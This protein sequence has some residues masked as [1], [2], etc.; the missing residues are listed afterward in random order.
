VQGDMRTLRLGRTFD[1]VFVHD[2]VMYV[3]TEDD[4]GAVIGTAAIHAAPGGVVILV[5]DTIRET[6]A[7]GVHEGGHDG[8]DDR[9]LRYLEWT[10]APD[11]GGTTFEVDYAIM[12]REPGEQVRVVHDHHLLGLFGR[13]TWRRLIDD[14]GLDLLDVAA[15]E[16]PH[17][18][19]FETFAAQRPA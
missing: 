2:A 9:S 12:L 11:P 16:H 3:T 13:D 4:L 1:A 17:P 8:P 15:I 7:P 5:P 14:A 6:F 19:E 18:G 10:H